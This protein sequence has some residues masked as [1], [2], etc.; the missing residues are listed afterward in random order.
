MREKTEGLVEGSVYSPSVDFQVGCHSDILVH[1]FGDDGLGAL[2]D[3]VLN[4]SILGSV[5]P[6]SKDNVLMTQEMVLHEGRTIA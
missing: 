1:M 3:V 2:E 4:M 6:H 5:L